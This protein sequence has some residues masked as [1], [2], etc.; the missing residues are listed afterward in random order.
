MVKLLH[1]YPN[2]RLDT[3]AGP[4]PDTLMGSILPSYRYCDSRK[5]NGVITIE[6]AKLVVRLAG[7][8][9]RL[10]LRTSIFGIQLNK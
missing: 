1:W 3:S 8:L 2:I 9:I 6:D 7:E 10:V 5:P 4:C